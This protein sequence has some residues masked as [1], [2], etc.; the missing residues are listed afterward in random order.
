MILPSAS[1]VALSL[2]LAA[3]LA[4]AV[5]AIAAARLQA[6]AAHL[7]LWLAWLLHGSV[8]AWGMLQATPRFGFAPALSVTVWL[9]LTVYAIERQLFPQMQARWALAALGSAAVLLALVF[10]GN[11]L[12]HSA[13]AWLPLHLA[14]GIA[15]YG[16]LAAAVVH[17]ALMMRAERRI[18]QAE[19][20]ASGMPLLTLERLTFRFVT[21]GFVLLTA[22]LAA[23]VL[24]SE[25]LYGRAWRWDHKAVFSLLSWA[26]FAA[27]LLGRRRF[28][29]RGRA[30]VRMLYAGA[31]LLLL[32]YVGSRFA[33]EVVLGRAA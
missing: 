26:T 29:W 13:S 4:Y 31:I 12:P 30:A 10:P 8:L 22:T 7:A 20:A 17:A 19:D 21:A 3:A 2:G 28:G 6:R 5:P 33:L 11:A 24:F 23:G 25:A 15:A 18:R 1:P 9:V 14:L 27:L 16:L 32:A